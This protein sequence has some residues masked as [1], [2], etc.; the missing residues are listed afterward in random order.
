MF[1]LIDA[2]SMKQNQEIVN[3]MPKRRKNDFFLVKH[4]LQLKSKIEIPSIP[5]SHRLTLLSSLVYDENENTFTKD[6][7]QDPVFYNIG[8]IS[9][10]YDI[11]ANLHP[12]D[13]ME[14]HR[15]SDIIEAVYLTNYYKE[16]EQW[17]SN[18]EYLLVK[19][20]YGDFVAESDLLR[21]ADKY[22][23]KLI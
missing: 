23:E 6:R 11:V 1:Y 7:F 16:Y 13:I 8:I 4:T 21:L 9:V 20:I 3:N 2:H 22:P 14:K 19:A 15:R 12:E 17:F 18:D 5:S 10:V